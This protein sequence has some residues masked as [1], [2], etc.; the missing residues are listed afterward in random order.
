MLLFNFFRAHLLPFL[1]VASFFAAPKFTHADE[2]RAEPQKK[3]AEV[4]QAVIARLTSAREQLEKDPDYIQTI[5]AYLI[6]PHVDFARLTA[7]TLTDHWQGLSAGERRCLTI[8]IREQ[9]VQ[10]YAR[11]LLETEYHNIVTDP[12]I[13][14]TE[15]GTVLVSQTV[16]APEP[17]PLKVKYRLEQ[18]DQDWRIVDLI[19]TDVSLVAS[20]RMSFATKIN[21]EGIGDFL[22]TF[23][24]CR[25][26]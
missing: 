21:K 22:R 9:I 25:E 19:V 26:R 5:V 16:A 1:V 4:T 3:V 7:A 2:S 6:L 8:G 11:V 18:V 20:Y 17:S 15:D 10:R 23:P 14:K 24:A 12:V 13:E